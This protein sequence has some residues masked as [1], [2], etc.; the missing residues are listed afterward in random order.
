MEYKLIRSRRKTLG[1]EISKGE[2]I[3]RAPLRC[4]LREI[5]RFVESREGWIR[6]RLAASIS[7][8]EAAAASHLSAEEIASLKQEARAFFA[9]RCEYFAALLGVEYALVTV[10]C[11]KTRWGSCSRKGGLSF[12]CLL[13][14]APREVA[15][16]VVVHELCHLRHF[17][18]S[19]AFYADVLSIMPDY[20]EREAWLKKEGRTLLLRA[21]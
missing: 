6:P 15:D 7:Q 19:P 18:H 10:R 1:L 20:R 16:S 13:M 3:V 21:T 17:D 14:L 2:V 9:G 8:T 11:Q 4:P 12:N 5:E